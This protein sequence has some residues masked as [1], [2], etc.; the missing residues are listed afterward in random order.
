M[1]WS[2]PSPKVRVHIICDGTGVL[3]TESALVVWEYLITLANEVNIFWKKPLNATSLL[4]IVTRWIMLANALLQFV[5]ITETTFD[6]RLL[7][8]IS[9][10][11]TFS[12]NCAALNWVTEALFLVQ[13]LATACKQAH[14]TATALLCFLN[15]TQYS[16]PYEYSLYGNEAIYGPALCCFWESL[17]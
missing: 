2:S 7:L 3:T 6:L 5:P 12:S 10:I 14:F 4:F 17:L 8:C 11:N 16:P 1:T 9:D 15:G 13:F